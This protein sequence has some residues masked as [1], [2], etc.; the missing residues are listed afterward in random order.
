MSTFTSIISNSHA[1][2]VSNATS[3]YAG[4]RSRK[5]DTKRKSIQQYNAEGRLL[6]IDYNIVLNEYIDVSGEQKKDK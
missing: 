6:I 3:E 4:L 2:H 5:N 1:K